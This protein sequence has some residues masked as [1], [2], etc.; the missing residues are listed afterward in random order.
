MTTSLNTLSTIS[1]VFD[2]GNIEYVSSEFDA[3]GTEHIHLRIRPDTN[4]TFMQWFHFRVQTHG[5]HTLR[6]I[7]DNAGQASYAKGFHGYQCV[8]SYDRKTWF[9]LPSTS[10][11]GTAL[12]I[13]VSPQ[14]NVL[15]LA[16][17]E[18]YSYEQH[19]ALLGE[20]AG[21]RYA[22][23]VESLGKSVQG[24]DIDLVRVGTPSPAKK[25]LWIIARQHPGES[26]A[27]W[28]AQGLLRR[29]MDETDPVAREIRE[30]AC[31]YIVPNMNPDGAVLGNLRTNAAGTNLNREWMNPSLEKSPEIVHVQRAMKASGADLFLDLHGDE[32]LPYIFVDGSHMVPGYGDRNLALQAAFLDDFLLA[33]P[34]FQLEHGYADNRFDNELLT[35]GSKWMAHTFGCVAIT[36]ELPF[37]D[38]A[39]APDPARGWDGARSERVGEALLYPILGHLKRLETSE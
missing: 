31:L 22:H 36:L 28:C 16:Y 9:R 33:S 8:A 27:Q 25:N 17:F 13:D 21:S 5:E 35:L 37:K 4:S 15:W 30:R 19:Q 1:S 18:P 24:R 2:S 23:R 32:T 29:L 3:K 6:L 39:N 12:T 10:F 11:D 26:M 38:N 20:C 34:D 14:H 7:I